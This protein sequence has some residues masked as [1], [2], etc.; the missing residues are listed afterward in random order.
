MKTDSPIC[1]PVC[2][3]TLVPTKWR[4]ASCDAE[5]A[6][7]FALNEYAALGEEDLHFLRIF[8]RCEGRLRDME[9]AL[10]ISYP[11]IKMRIAQ[12][13]ETLAELAAANILAAR[14]QVLEQERTAALRDLEDGRATF[15][16]TLAR[17]KE[18]N[19]GSSCGP[20]A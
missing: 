1:C 17:F 13:H 6:G 9:P 2:E 16:Q 10:G 7:R 3:G 19:P 8:V 11:T 18:K 4:C 12:L 14:E 15:E 5:V 20:S